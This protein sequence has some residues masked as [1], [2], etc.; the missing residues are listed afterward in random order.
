MKRK[1]FPFVLIDRQL[2]KFSSNYVGVDIFQ[3]AYLTTKHLINNEYRKI[4]FLR[5]LPSH[6]LT[7]NDREAGCRAASKE[8]NIRSSS[9]LI[10]NINCDEQKSTFIYHFHC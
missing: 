5:I 7:I 6:L 9:K 4:G 10:R 1:N 3:G 2:P 8:N